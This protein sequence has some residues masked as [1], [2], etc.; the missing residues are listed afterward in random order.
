LGS[1]AVGTYND[2]TPPNTAASTSSLTHKK[3]SEFLKNSE[4]CFSQTNILTGCS[5][6]FASV[7][8]KAAASTPSSTHKKTS[9]VCYFHTN[10]LTGCSKYL[11]SV[12]INAAASAPGIDWHILDAQEYNTH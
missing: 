2:A 11:A 9:E 5:K 3:T 8:I 4:V 1:R 12:R 6:Y 10:I 7:R